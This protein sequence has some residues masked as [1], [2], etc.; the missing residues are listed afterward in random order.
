MKRSGTISI[1]HIALALVTG[2]LVLVSV[3]GGFAAYQTREVTRSLEQHNHNAARS[4]LEASVQR[5]ITQT[6]EQAQALARW[7]ETRQ[8]LVLSEYYSYWRDQ[9]VYESG[10]LPARFARAALYTQAGDVLA[11]SPAKVSLPSR[12]PAVASSHQP[13]TWLANEAGTIALYHA[14]PIY[15]DERRQSLLGHGLVRLDF[16][17]SLLRQ[18]PLY[19]TNVASLHF[20][21]QPSET[22]EASQLF[23]RLHFAARPDPDQLR[24]QTILSRTLLALFVLLLATAMIGFVAY[25]RLL[26]RP[27]RGLSHDIDAMQQ[28]RFSPHPSRSQTLR[29]SELE[30]IRRSLYDYQLQLRELHGSLEHQNREFHSQAR[31]D[32]LTGCHNRRAYEE[33]WESFR[34][35][36]RASPQGVAFLLFDCDRFKTIND[37]YGHAK[38]DRV[39]TIIADALVMALRAND[40]LYRLGGDEF[41]TFLS[42]TTPVQAKQIAQRC[43][44]LLDA[45]AFSD[46]GI[47]EPVGISIGIAF[48]PAEHPELID[49][50][51]KQADIAMYT[52]KQPGRNRIALYGEDTERAAQALVASRETNAL[53][54][55]LSTP[56]MIEMHYQ[57]IHGLPGRQVDYYEALARIRYNG[58]LIRPDAFLPVVSNRRLETE[59]DLAVLNQVDADLSSRALPA[60]VGVSINLSAQSISRPE[61]VSHLLEL[62]RHNSRHPLMLEITE[63][64]LITQMAEVSTYLELLRTVHYR[65]AMDDFG[66]GYSPLRYL[67]DLPVDVVKFDISL[68]NKLAQDNRAGQVVADFAR[69]MSEAGYALVAEGVETEAVLNKVE[70]LGIAHVQG[71]LLSRP[72]PLAEIAAHAGVEDVDA[73]S[74]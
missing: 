63:T 32:A 57:S 49:E 11:P 64:S 28:G 14:F 36:T 33:D 35:E 59:F 10:M 65:I 67:V 17:A 45:S 1:K 20:A 72:V 74:T 46:L 21:L 42:R 69:M 3:I 61:V 15:S 22:V 60:G 50:L 9:R 13:A 37:T 2:L 27:L 43:Q 44:S 56:G 30:N 47:S 58:D 53:F 41:A 8:Q 5:L 71:Y 70:S 16:M 26:V 23:S 73:C 25:N 7:D 52:A 55:A 29:V 51:P 18:Q 34:E 24:F 12:L 66:T 48:C 62:S 40:R 6:Q 54:Q 19:F 68:V 4:E 31:Q 38:G 39:L